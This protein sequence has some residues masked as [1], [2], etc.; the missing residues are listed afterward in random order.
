M[1]RNSGI[2][3]CIHPSSVNDRLDINEIFAIPEYAGMAR[4]QMLRV[5]FESNCEYGIPACGMYLRERVVA[6]CPELLVR[7]SW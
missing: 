2:P 3:L 5:G 4:N 6:G 7:D 1:C